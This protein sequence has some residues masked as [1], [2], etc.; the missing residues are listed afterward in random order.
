MK[1]Y[2]CGPINGCSDSECRDWREAAKNEL[3]DTIDPMRRDYRGKELENYIEIVEQDKEDIEESDV[4]LV[5]YV[6]P[7]VGTAMEILFA[8]ELGFVEVVVVAKPGTVI[9]PWLK[10]HAHQIFHTFTEAFNYIRKLE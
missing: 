3:Q 5:N 9:S 7:S 6:K 8:W 1:T 10:Y 2:L 4:L